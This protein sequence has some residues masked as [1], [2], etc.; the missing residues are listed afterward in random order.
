MLGAGVRTFP[1]ERRGGST[2]LAGDLLARR[3][4][5]VIFPEGTRS[6]DGQLGRFRFGAAALAAAYSVP[7]VP[8]GIRG[9]YAAMPRGRGWPVPGRPPVRVR[10]G[11]PLHASPDEDVRAF[12]R[13]IEAGV[14]RVLAEDSSTW[15]ESMRSPAPAPSVAGPRWR[16]VWAATE[17]ATVESE[18]RSAWR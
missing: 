8:I 3:L 13:R 2:G 14:R 6:A 1:I 11:P 16:R 18:R 9:S 7:V 10:L 5:V 15:W 4:V 17:P 12:T